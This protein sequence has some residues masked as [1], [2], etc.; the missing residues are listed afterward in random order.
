[1]SQHS[2]ERCPR[3][4][5]FTVSL[6][7]ACRR[8]PLRFVFRVARGLT[9]HESVAFLLLLRP[10]VPDLVHALVG[11]PTCPPDLDADSGQRGSVN[12]TKRPDDPA[13]GPHA[14]RSCERV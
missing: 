3:S 14:D 9:T 5:T 8:T 10:S 4:W 6:S 13:T 1:M 2:D 12:G 11:S 7:A